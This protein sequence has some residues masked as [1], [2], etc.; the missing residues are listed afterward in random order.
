[1]N[2]VHILWI[3][4]TNKFLC[5]N[6]IHGRS[7]QRESCHLSDAVQKSREVG[8]SG[9]AEVQSEVA[10]VSRKSGCTQHIVSSDNQ[11]IQ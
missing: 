9:F 3:Q 2:Q 10:D 4:P 5:E 6:V 7:G 1:M 8:R 11:E